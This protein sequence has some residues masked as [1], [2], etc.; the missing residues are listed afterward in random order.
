[1]KGRFAV[2][3]AGLALFASTSAFAEIT[4]PEGTEFA[5]RLEE[6]ISSATAT[7]GDRFTVSLDD[8]VKLPDGTILRAGYRGVGEV[9]EARDNGMLGKN[10]KLN[11][12][13]VY[14]KVG[15]DRIRLRANKG[16]KGETRVGATVATVILFW[17]AAPF[18]KGRDVSI[19]KGTMMTAYA[20]QDT[21]LSALPPPPP[22]GVD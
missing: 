18:I 19:K 14:L 15:D 8:D 7:E 17:P 20:D 22:G 21:K 6:A 2:V 3:F 13:L 9:V 11:V 4:V 16:T 1:M 10:G 12:R 5:L